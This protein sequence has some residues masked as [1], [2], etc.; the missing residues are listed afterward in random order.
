MSKSKETR[1][2]TIDERLDRIE[3]S[4]DLTGYENNDDC[5]TGAKHL[6]ELFCHLNLLAGIT[7]IILLVFFDLPVIVFGCMLIFQLF[8]LAGAALVAA[9]TTIRRSAESADRTE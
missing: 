7:A 2:L 8:M 1:C 6:Y 3:K 9:V 4:L 5:D